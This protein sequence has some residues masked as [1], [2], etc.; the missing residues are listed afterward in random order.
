M[1][2]RGLAVLA[3]LVVLTALI[4]AIQYE[5]LDEGYEAPPS[6]ETLEKQ[7]NRPPGSINLNDSDAT[8]SAQQS[9]P[10]EQPAI[11]D[12]FKAKKRRPATER[13]FLCLQSALSKEC[14]FESCSATRYLQ[15]I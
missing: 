11:A 9:P 7:L 4:V 1:V 10:A 2:S 14:K 6:E 12:P 8:A 13:I 15:R 5:I 3:I